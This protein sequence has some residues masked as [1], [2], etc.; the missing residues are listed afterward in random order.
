[1]HACVLKSHNLEL[2]ELEGHRD[3]GIAAC[4]MMLGDWATEVGNFDTAQQLFAQALPVLQNTV[5]ASRQFY[6]ELLYA[7]GGLEAKLGNC[8]EA[9]KLFVQSLEIAN[10]L[11]YIY[12]ISL[13]EAD[14]SKSPE[15]SL[16]C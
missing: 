16:K 3:W 9:R 15:V 5:D 10:G 1:M 4:Q 14:L 12:L 2:V 7:M 8:A 11:G 13:V 6:A